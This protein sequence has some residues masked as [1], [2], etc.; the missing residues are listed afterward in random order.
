MIIV[1]CVKDLKT[2]LDEIGENKQSCFYNEFELYSI[3]KIQEMKFSDIK[4]YKFSLVRKCFKLSIE[5]REIID[6][7]SEL[8]EYFIT[9]K[10]HSVFSKE[11][12]T[13]EYKLQEYL[14]NLEREDEYE[15]LQYFPGK[16]LSYVG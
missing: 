8:L 16:T 5:D 15:L 1:N 13:S 10:F 3:G 7:Y 4:K 12:K 11:L 9:L 6:W 2:F 14:F